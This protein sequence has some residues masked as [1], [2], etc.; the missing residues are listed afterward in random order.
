MRVTVAAGGYQLPDGRR[1]DARRFYTPGVGEVFV[2]D[3]WRPGLELE[4]MGAL[5]TTMVTGRPGGGR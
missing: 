3:A 4:S 5:P 1:T 2:G